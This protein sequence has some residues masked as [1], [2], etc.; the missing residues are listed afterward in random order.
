MYE[1]DIS[2][3]TGVKKLCIKLKYVTRGLEV[4]EKSKELFLDCKDYNLTAT[5]ISIRYNGIF[6]DTSMLV[7]KLRNHI[8]L[9]NCP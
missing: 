7:G 5:D 6:S 8:E 9:A 4:L 2:S 1:Y 3:F